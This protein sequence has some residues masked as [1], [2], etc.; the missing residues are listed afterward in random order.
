MASSQPSMSSDHL[1]DQLD[2]LNIVLE[3]SNQPH[4]RKYH[5]PQTA[6]VITGSSEAIRGEWKQFSC[7]MMRLC[8]HRLTTAA[9]KTEKW[10]A[11]TGFKLD[12]YELSFGHGPQDCFSVA[13]MEKFIT[14]RDIAQPEEWGPNVEFLRLYLD[15]TF[16]RAAELS[17]SQRTLIGFYPVDSEEPTHV[18]FNTGLLTRGLQRL[19][20]LFHLNKKEG[21]PR[22]FLYGFQ[23][24]SQLINPAKM[25]VYHGT[26]VLNAGFLPVK[27]T[28]HT[29][30]AELIMDPSIPIETRV[31]LSHLFGGSNDFERRARIPPKYHNCGL[32]DLGAKFHHALGRLKIL[33]EAQPTLAVPQ[34]FRDKHM[35]G[36]GEIQFVCPLSLDPDNQEVVDCC[37]VVRRVVN[38][39]GDFYQPITVLSRGM[40]FNHCRLIQKP[41]QQWL[42][43]FM[44][45]PPK[46]EQRT[47]VARH[48]M[49]TPV[50]QSDVKKVEQ[51]ETQ[52]FQIREM[53]VVVDIIKQNFSHIE[54]VELASLAPLLKQRIPRLKEGKGLC[55][56]LVLAAAEKRFVKTVVKGKQTYISII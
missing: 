49:I 8:D 22:W 13:L 12:D 37:V 35:N 10:A 5:F 48:E 56:E 3:Q 16:R 45:P 27:I 50:I 36:I 6:A 17:K 28:Y 42:I 41:T 44:K 7:N 47:P 52:D 2:M 18:M 53:L 32:G 33:I 9:A 38:S 34:F 43:D 15:H 14:L 54:Q 24:E 55:K 39:A 21:G 40:V 30:I 51:T 11:K 25:K 46:T 4:K 31:D 29:T 19:Y 1:L 26:G 23:D 20:V